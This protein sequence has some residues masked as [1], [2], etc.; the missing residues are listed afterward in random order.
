V[1]LRVSRVTSAADMAAAL[2]GNP[3][4]NPGDRPT[5]EAL[6]QMLGEGP[7]GASQRWEPADWNWRLIDA[8]AAVR[9]AFGA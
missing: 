3:A 5:L 6:R 7:E 2:A 1:K 9:S 4:W 8:R